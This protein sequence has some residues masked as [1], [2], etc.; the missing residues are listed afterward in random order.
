ML[1]MGKAI[2]FLISPFHMAITSQAGS[3]NLHLFT[4][5]IRHTLS[6]QKL[7]ADAAPNLSGEEGKP[8][9]RQSTNG[10]TNPEGTQSEHI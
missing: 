2:A 6:F 7:L 4:E 9:H 3:V 8:K 1:L 5:K 10:N